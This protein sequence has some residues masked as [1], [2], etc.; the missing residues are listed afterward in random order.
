VLH[1]NVWV[2]EW[3]LCVCL[4]SADFHA[5]RKDVSAFLRAVAHCYAKS[6]EIDDA[7]DSTAGIVAGGSDEEDDARTEYNRGEVPADASGPTPVLTTVTPRR[8]RDLPVQRTAAANT[9]PRSQPVVS[10]SQSSPQSTTWPVCL[11]VIC[12]VPCRHCLCCTCLQ[13]IT[14]TATGCAR[15]PVC[16]TDI[17]DTKRLHFSA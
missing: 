4:L 9:I 12:D 2:G 17:T 15:C 3:G 11:M 10:T 7:D 16:R 6:R 5:G 1:I 14:S 8:L 13:N